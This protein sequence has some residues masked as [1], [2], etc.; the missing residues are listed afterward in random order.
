MPELLRFAI[1]VPAALL[2]ILWDRLTRDEFDQ[3]I[4]EQRQRFIDMHVGE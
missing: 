4:A 1:A 3:F 2:G